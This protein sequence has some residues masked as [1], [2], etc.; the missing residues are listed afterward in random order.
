MEIFTFKDKINSK[1][2]IIDIV[3][4]ETPTKIVPS[5]SFFFSF[6]FSLSLFLLFSISL[7]YLI[8][9]KI[10]SRHDESSCMKHQCF[11]NRHEI[12]VSKTLSKKSKMCIRQTI[13]PNMIDKSE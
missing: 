7:P 8:Y 5:P 12:W 13:D 4:L 11:P 2:L 6:S 1:N 9:F 3:R 10:L